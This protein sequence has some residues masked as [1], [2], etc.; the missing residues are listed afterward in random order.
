[1]DAIGEALQHLSSLTALT[2]NLNA[3]RNINK[4]AAGAALAGA[5]EALPALTSVEVATDGA[6]VADWKRRFEAATRGRAMRWDRNV[7]YGRLKGVVE[8]ASSA[9]AS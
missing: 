7:S 5:L 4:D 1:M 3:C 6:A 2:L 9:G 8:A